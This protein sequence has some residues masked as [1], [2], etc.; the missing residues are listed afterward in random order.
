LPFTNLEDAIMQANATQYGLA[1]SVF[2][3]NSND[4]QKCWEELESGI[5]NLNKSTVGASSKLPFGG[6]KKSGNHWPTAI[7]ATRYCTYPVASI[8]YSGPVAKPDEIKAKAETAYPGINW[9]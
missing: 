2:T 9:E 5:I 4:Y 6:L 3:Q 8:E 1:S 7:T